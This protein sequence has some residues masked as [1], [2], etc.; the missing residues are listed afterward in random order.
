MKKLLLVGLSG[1]LFVQ[2]SQK[3]EPNEYLIK[4]KMENVEKGAYA[5]L[6][7]EDRETATTDS[8]EI[9]KNA[10]VFRGTVE[11]EAKMASLIIKN[12]DAP[13]INTREGFENAA[14]IYVEP[15]LIKLTSPTA[16]LA[17]AVFEGPPNT[18]AY[19][20]WNNEC[21]LLYE[22][23]RTIRNE[24]AKLTKDQKTAENEEKYR[25]DVQEN[26]RKQNEVHRKHLENGTNTYFALQWLYGRVFP[27]SSDP[28]EAQAMLDRFTPEIK[29]SKDGRDT[30]ARLNGRKATVLGKE[31]PH[32]TAHT[33]EGKP[34]SVADFRGKYLFIDF[35][36][37]WCSPCR[38]ENPHVVAAYK[39][40]KGKNFEIL[41]V[42]LDFPQQEEAWIQAIK[43]D[44]LSWPQVSDL[45]GWDCEAAKLY[46]VSAI[47]HNVLLDPNGIIV[48]KNLRGE[49]LAETLETFLKK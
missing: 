13:S 18:A 10:F 6:V 3:L 12:A 36:A 7:I 21:D 4:G 1:L 2:C 24:Y 30:Q 25:K 48:A 33:P 8:V 39:K 31:A 49:K 45:Q 29:E 44:N 20:A 28:D 38:A 14:L 46:G 27:S 42:S 26:S 16:L 47:P 19:Y 37:S 32:F 9:V 11:S 34:I 15:G 22:E 5:Y 40:Y 35:W 41:G 17:D 23:I 43:D